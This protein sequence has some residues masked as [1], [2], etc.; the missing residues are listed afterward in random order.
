M[1][2]LKQLRE[3]EPFNHIS[4][5]A[6]DELEAL[7]KTAVYPADTVIFTQKSNPSGFL[8]FIRKGQVEISAETSEGVEMVVDYRN[9]G[10]FFGWSPIFTGETY[11]AG[12]KTTEET[13]CL[14]IPKE[15]LLAL[16]QQYPIISNYFNKAIYSQIRKLYREM[17]EHKSLDPVAQMEAYPFQKRLREMMSRPV[18]TC[19]MNTPVQEVALKMTELDIAAI[20]V[21]DENGKMTGIVTERD[22]VR[23]VLATD[24]ENC[25][26]HYTAKDVMT[27][28]PYFMTPDTYMY[29]AATFMLRHSI[30]HLPIIEGSSI[31]GIVSIQDLMKFRSQKSMLLVGSAKEAETI[32]ELTQIRGE[33]FKVAKILLAENRSHVET[34]EILSYIH[35]S[36]IR[37]CFE[38][39][40]LSMIKEGHKAPPIKYSFIIMGSG[41]RKEMLLGP[42]QDNGFIF[43]DYPEELHEEVE[44]FFDP[45]AERLVTALADVGYPLCNGQVMV[46]NPSWRGR[47]SEWKERVSR[48]IR[49]PEPQRVR[50][51]SIFFDFMPIL[52]E[53]SLCESLRETVFQEIKANP[54][55]LFQMMELDFKHKVPLNLIGRFITS[56][57]K[58]HKGK[59]SLKENGSIFIVDC[60][61]MFTLQQ[62]IHA[63]TTLDRLDVLQ[64]KKLFNRSTIENL[65][66][67]F[68]SFTYL[69]LQNEINLIEQGEY[70][71]HYLD[72]DTLSEQEADLLKEAFKVTS[73]LQDSTKR[74]FSKIIGR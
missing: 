13:H 40:M 50:Y 44:A 26:K 58:D 57:E 15:P 62:G 10:G 68:E 48:W 55:F 27:P 42:D 24:T 71:S 6:A 70:P 14:L 74:Y 9:I 2:D 36:I 5:K 61:R 56:G 19:R 46:N 59:L 45:L 4:E 65:K 60:A 3:C 28:N 8:Y 38:L 25:L 29:E 31:A 16:A 20:V 37:R 43:E 18:K 7:S 23:K 69:R 72:P 64:E 35:H 51:S 54:L 11:A 67:A 53:E 30:R 73:K 52:G 21:C 1:I 33:I 41:G 12:A 66:A 32:E 22:M 63:V 49:V 34:M 17:T 39:V 47:L